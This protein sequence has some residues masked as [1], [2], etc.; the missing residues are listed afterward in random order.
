MIVN[1]RTGQGVFGQPNG[2]FSLYVSNGDSISISV[3]G[4]FVVNFKVEAD[5]DCQFRRKVYLNPKLRNL[6]KKLWF[7]R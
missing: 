7:D 2:S 3:T 4:Y 5:V 6:L 1:R